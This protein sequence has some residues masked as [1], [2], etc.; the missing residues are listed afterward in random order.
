MDART[1]EIRNVPE[2]TEC[3]LYHVKHHVILDHLYT[4]MVAFTAVKTLIL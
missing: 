1:I 3:A 2:K 4:V